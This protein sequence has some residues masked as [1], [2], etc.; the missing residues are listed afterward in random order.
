MGNARTG[1]R[2]E[3]RRGVGCLVLLMGGLALLGTF[4]VMLATLL[5]GLSGGGNVVEVAESGPPQAARKLAIIEVQGVLLDTPTSLVGSSRGTTKNALAMLDRAI[6]DDAVAGVLL[7]LDTPGGSVTDADLIHHRIRR[8]REKNKK[9]VVQMGDICASGGVYA[10]VAADEIWAHPTTLTGS[11]GVIIQSLNV[12]DLLQRHGVADVSVTSGENKALL[13]PTLPVRAEHRRILQDIVDKLHGRFVR[14][15]AEGRALEEPVVRA[16]ADGR[17]LTA[18]EA[19]EAK[20]IDGI[21]YRE[22]VLARLESVAEGGPFRVVRYERPSS[23]L[24]FLEARAGGADLAAEALTR[25]FA[26]PRAMYLFAAP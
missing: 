10:A 2:K 5:G 20:L 4:G 3:A 7:R 18:D 13:S 25:V 11:I 12:H 17:I 14:I 24:A 6:A 1:D 8:L 19:K 22:D 26:S 16:I 21:G 15:V 23:P 9:V